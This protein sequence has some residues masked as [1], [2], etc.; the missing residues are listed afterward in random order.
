MT[1]LHS[2][3]KIQSLSRA[4]KKQKISQFIYVSSILIL[5]LK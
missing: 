1:N 5:V 3:H 4:G 2:S